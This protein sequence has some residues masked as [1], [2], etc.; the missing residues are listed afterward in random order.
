[1]L[2]LAAAAGLKLENAKLMNLGDG[3]VTHGTVKELRHDSG[4]DAKAIIAAGLEMCNKA[5]EIV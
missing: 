4:I 3:I 1:M 2:S 5:M